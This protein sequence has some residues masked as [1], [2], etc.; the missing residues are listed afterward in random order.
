MDGEFWWILAMASLRMIY[1]ASALVL[2]I[3]ITDTKTKGLLF[4][5]NTFRTHI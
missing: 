3:Q 4:I 5:T 2:A 1:T